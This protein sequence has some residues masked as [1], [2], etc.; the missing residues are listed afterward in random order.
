VGGAAQ[1]SACEARGMAAEGI[2]E[3]GYS[4]R[5]ACQLV[6]IEPKTFGDRSRRPDDGTSPERLR[7]LAMERR[8]CGYRRLHIPLRREGL[9]ANHKKLFRL[10]REERL[11]VRKVGGRKRAVRTRAPVAVPQGPNQRWSLDSYLTRSATG[12]DSGFWVV[13]DFTRERV[14]LV[15]DVSLSGLRVGRELDRIGELRGYPALIVSD[16]G[17]ELTSHAIARWQEERSVLWYY[18]APGNRNKMGLLRVLTAASGMNAS[19]S[20]SSRTSP[21]H[22]GSSKRGGS[23]TTPSA[24][25]RDLAGPRPQSLQLARTDDT[26]RTGC[27]L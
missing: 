22:V 17:T 5:R 23:T 20:T 4:Q 16:N 2:E 11:S 10:Y 7:A 1:G 25:A 21:L 3:R 6:G 8:W 13:D 27:C 15:G 18:I 9:R 24:H 12:D 14:G 26:R 19:T